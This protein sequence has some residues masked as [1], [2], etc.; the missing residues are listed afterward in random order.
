MYDWLSDT[1][2]DKTTLVTANRRL[3]R[4][5]REEFG[6]QQ[7][8]AGI[9]AWRSPDIV[10]WPDWIAR[11]LAGYGSATHL[12][13]HQSQLLWERCLRRELGDSASGV[14]T[15]VRLARD[16]WQRLSDARVG[17]KDVAASSQNDDHRMFAAAAGTYLAILDGEGWVDDALAGEAVLKLLQSKSMIIPGRVVLAGFDRDNASQRA[18]CDALQASGSEVVRRLDDPKP[19]H[20]IQMSFENSD[21]EMRA[22]G[23]W[24]RAELEENPDSRIAIIKHGLE[25]SADRDV[26]LLREGFVPGW[27]YG[28]RAHASAVNVSYGRKLSD[29]PAVAVALLVLRWLGRDIGARDVAALLMSPFVG[30]GEIADRSRLELRLRDLPDRAWSPAMISSALKQQD[31]DSNFLKRIAALGRQRRELPQRATPAA[32]AEL[33]SSVLETLGWPGPVGLDSHSYQLVNR[34]R[35]L[36][37]TFARLN[38]VSGTMSAAQAIARIDAIAGESVFQPESVDA[39]IQL[40]GP[41]EASGLEFDAIWIA[42]LTATNWPAAGHPSPLVSRKLQ[43][44]HRMP[45]ATPADT[46]AFSDKVLTRLLAS[47]EHAVCSWPVVTDD[48]EQTVSELLRQRNLPVTDSSADP[49]WHALKLRNEAAPV[50]HEDTVPAVSDEKIFGGAGTLDAQ[51]SE[52]FAAFVQGRLGAGWLGRQAVG[53]PP[54]LRGNVIHEALYRLYQDLPASAALKALSDTE[55]DHHV[56][57]AVSAA[58]VPHERNTD[59][60]LLRLLQME[61]SRISRLVAQFVQLDRE[62]AEFRVAGVEGKLEFEHGGL[63]LSLRFDRI[64]EFT[65]GSIAILDYKTGTTRELLTKKGVVREPQLFVYAMAADAPVA[66]LALVNIDSREIVVSGGGRGFT[67][68]EL[69]PELLAAISDE[70]GAAAEAFAAGDVRIDGSQTVAAA[71]PLNVLSRFTELRHDD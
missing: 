69:W 46:L 30:E 63:R 10:A 66:A 24:A 60:V 47:A 48:G 54:S 34:W 49:G 4:T 31:V 45:D 41:L 59:A 56:A 36:L 17:I 12:N 52:P 15:A 7:V 13:Q 2:D 21:S 42:G 61:R 25:Q 6:R 8:D 65:D 55:I 3:V 50:Q 27:Q 14:T 9:T 28:T 35:E 53:I 43:I 51:M 26:R 18:I 68:E 37:N 19:V 62:R 16:T 71:R 44:E 32:W 29:Y 22:A 39:A 33:L 38:L 5:L 23:A 20:A 11:L 67:D 1:L 58:F 64:D 57:E 40:L 70:I